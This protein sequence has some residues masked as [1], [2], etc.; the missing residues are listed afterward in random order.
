LTSIYLRI[1]ACDAAIWSRASAAAYRT[2]P[3]LKVEEGLDLLVAENLMVRVA[4]GAELVAPGQS[5]SPGC[6]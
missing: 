4:V 2:L 6:M 1:R 5:E 3:L